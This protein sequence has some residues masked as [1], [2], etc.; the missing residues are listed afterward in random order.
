MK[1]F[2]KTLLLIG[3]T[4][5]AKYDYKTN[6]AD[7]GSIVMDG[8]KCGTDGTNQSPIDLKT[9]G[10]TLK[11]SNFDNFNK[12]YT[13][14]TVEVEVKWNGHTSQVNLDTDPKTST[15]TISSSHAAA[16]HDAGTTYNGV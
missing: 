13:D 14:Q 8:N 9:K 1:S 2:L 11:D 3:S 7:W 10:W 16:G 15:Q 5:A 12:I 6:G 4:N